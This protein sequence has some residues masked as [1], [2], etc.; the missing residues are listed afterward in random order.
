MSLVCCARQKSIIFCH[1]PANVLLNII[2]VLSYL[3]QTF[4]AF[5]KSEGSLLYWSRPP[6]MT[7]FFKIQF[8]IILPSTL[9]GPYDLFSPGFLSKT[10][11]TFSSVIICGCFI[12]HLSYHSWKGPISRLLEAYI[13]GRHRAPILSKQM[14]HVIW[15]KS[16]SGSAGTSRM[17]VSPSI[18]KGLTRK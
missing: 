12:T 1:K 2:N 8:N 13:F 15:N 4:L 17:V 5:T 10:V 3:R 6:V 9:S 14:C 11:Y 16:H 7:F 18:C